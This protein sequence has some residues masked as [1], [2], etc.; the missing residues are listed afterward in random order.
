[1][2]KLLEF[3]N[4][5]KNVCG[6]IKVEVTIYDMDHPWICYGLVTTQKEK[7]PNPNVPQILEPRK[8]HLKIHKR[9]PKFI[10]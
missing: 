9:Y 3:E 4:S 2:P 7:Q 5:T 8:L 6:K 10:I 1:M